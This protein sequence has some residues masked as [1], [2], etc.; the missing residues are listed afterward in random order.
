MLHLL[1]LDYGWA[2]AVLAMGFAVW[3][4]RPIVA[5]IEACLP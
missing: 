5:A 3:S 2:S 1:V 4:P